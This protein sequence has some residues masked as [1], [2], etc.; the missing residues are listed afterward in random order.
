MEPPSYRNVVILNSSGEN[1]DSRLLERAV[2]ET[3]VRHSAPAGDVSVLLTSDE[4]IRDLNSRFR[5]IDEATDV[6]TFPTGSDLLGSLGEI[7]VATDYATR[8]AALRGWAPQEEI[9]HLVI[10]GS[11]HLAGFDD[12]DEVPRAEML[13]EQNSIAASLGLPQDPEWSSLLH[14]VTA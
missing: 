8:Q 6:L 1:I 4:V 2:H 11:L 10:H 7:A 3:L 9:A 12:V 14:E 13:R 5:G